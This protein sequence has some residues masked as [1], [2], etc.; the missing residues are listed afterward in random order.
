MSK[1]LKVTF[2]AFALGRAA[3]NAQIDPARLGIQARR[4]AFQASSFWSRYCTGSR[5]HDGRLRPIPVG[6]GSS[7]TSCGC[8][9]FTTNAVALRQSLIRSTSTSESRTINPA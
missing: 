9:W 7:A 1:S 2:E 5:P 8:R 3:H 6:H 4:A